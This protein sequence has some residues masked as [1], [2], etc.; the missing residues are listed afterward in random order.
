MCA[1]VRALVAETSELQPT[2]GQGLPVIA[3]PTT[4]DRVEP[5]LSGQRKRILVKWWPESNV[6]HGLATAPTMG[7]T[8]KTR[9][10]PITVARKPSQATNSLTTRSC[11][12][13]FHVLLKKKAQLQTGS[14]QGGIKDDIK[15]I[16][17]EIEALGG[18]QKYQ[19]MSTVGQSNERGGGSHKIL[20]SWLK[21]MKNEL[22]SSLPLQRV[23]SS[24]YFLYA[25][26]I[27]LDLDHRLLEVGAL[28]P[29]NYASITS[30]ISVTPIDLHSQHP[31]IKEQDFFLLSQTENAHKWDVISLS[32][33]VN[34]VPEP[35]DRG[36]PI[37]LS[38]PKHEV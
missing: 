14:S 29:D 15:A 35:K 25:G 19:E 1:S 5:E 36:T 3:G 10:I 12:R 33:V 23:L 30:W 18:L 26:L 22:R 31:S 28:K 24:F 16:N 11:I 9:K 20:I 7:R 17:D 4:T 38:W 34:F 2:A 6:S 13:R 37:C 27:A 8:K 32:L 21:D